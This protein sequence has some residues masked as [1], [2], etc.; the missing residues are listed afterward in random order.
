MLTMKGMHCLKGD[1][2]FLYL[3]HSKGG[4]GLTDLE[5]THNCKCAALA[6]Y[7]LNSDNALMQ[8]VHNTPKPTQKFLLKFLSLPKLTTPKLTNELHHLRLKEMPLHG[9][10]FKQQEAIPKLTL[11]G[12][13]NGSVMLISDLKL[14]LQSA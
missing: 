11:T 10:F 12:C 3:H 9:K 14:R 2:H 1:I 6:T 4:R 7:V 8:I 13:T 5:D